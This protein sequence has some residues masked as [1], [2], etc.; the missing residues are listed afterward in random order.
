MNKVLVG[1]QPIFHK[2]MR[3]LGYELLF[4]DSD[5]NVATFANGDHATAQAICNASIEIGTK[6]VRIVSGARWFTT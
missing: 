5:H 3:V 4:R 1:R 2:D 6:P